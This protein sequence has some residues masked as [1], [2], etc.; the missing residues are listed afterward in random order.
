LL[1][2]I[3]K[4]VIVSQVLKIVNILASGGVRGHAPRAALSGGGTSRIKKMKKDE[5][6]GLTAERGVICFLYILKGT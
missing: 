4:F 1:V 2:L 3:V 5:D 6:A